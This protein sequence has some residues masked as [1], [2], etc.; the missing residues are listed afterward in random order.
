MKKILITG[1]N[2]YIGNSIENKLNM[3]E[4]KYDVSRLDVRT[5]NWKNNDFSYFDVVIHVAALVHIKESAYMESEYN[6]INKE[7]SIELADKAKNDG[8]KQFIFFSTMAIF[9]QVGLIGEKCTID[10][11]TIP[12]PKTYYAKSKYEAE[13]ELKKMITDNFR[14]AIIRPPM[15][16]GPN[17]KGNFRKLESLAIKLFVFPLVDN[18]RSMISIERLT[19]EIISIINKHS[20]GV[21]MPQDNEYINIS[22]LVKKLSESNGRKI[23]LI[24]IPSFCIKIVGRNKPIFNKVFGNLTYAKDFKED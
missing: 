23:L 6:K 3:I 15:V 18:E 2:G 13:I 1:A 11:N 7:L 12:N 16:Y 21:F 17:C 10:A 24:K 19:E 4:G 22:T 20:Q 8:V 14:I 5:D 9:G